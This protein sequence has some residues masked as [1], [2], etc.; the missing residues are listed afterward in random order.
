[1][2]DGDDAGEQKGPDQAARLAARSRLAGEE[3][4]GRQALRG[5]QVKL[6]RGASRASGFG[7]SSDC[8]AWNEN[9]WPSASVTVTIRADFSIEALEMAFAPPDGP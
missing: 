8:A 5:H 6:T 1:M 4:Q 2:R 9:V 7:G 3:V